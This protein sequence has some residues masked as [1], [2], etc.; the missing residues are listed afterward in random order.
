L[1]LLFLGPISQHFG[2]AINQLFNFYSFVTKQK[3]LD[4]YPQVIKFAIF[5]QRHEYGKK[6]LRNFFLV[7]RFIAARPVARYY[8][9]RK[10]H[11]GIIRVARFFLVK[12]TKTGRNIPNDHKFHQKAINCTKWLGIPNDHKIYQQFPFQ[13]ALMYII[14]PQSG[15]LV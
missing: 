10:L 11:R 3:N 1:L 7:Q 13:G 9:S 12:H 8:K 4:V 2:N 6:T 5:L 14:I 15:F